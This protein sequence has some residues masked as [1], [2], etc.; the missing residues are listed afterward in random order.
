M[1][2][3]FP[4]SG[5]DSKWFLKKSFFKIG[6]LDFHFDYW[7]PSLSNVYDV[8][9][10]YSRGCGRR[11][12]SSR[13]VWQSRRPVQINM[14]VKVLFSVPLIESVL[15]AR[16]DNAT[17]GTSAKAAPWLPR[18]DVPE[19]SDKTDRCLGAP[20]SGNIITFVII[21]SIGVNM[22]GS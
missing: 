15:M 11:R 21:N 9:L 20:V 1:Q 4:Q 6:I 22:K 19:S 18:A 7:H 12:W 16:V 14:I 10:S 3:T 17:R 5:N 13:F 8:D 2:N